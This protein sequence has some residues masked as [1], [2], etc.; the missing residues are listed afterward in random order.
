MQK[1]ERQ[2]HISYTNYKKQCLAKEHL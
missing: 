1:H 2:T